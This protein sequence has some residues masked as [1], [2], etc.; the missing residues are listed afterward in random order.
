M[1]IRYLTNTGPK[2]IDNNALGEKR[3]ETMFRN[4]ETKGGGENALNFNDNIAG[5]T[6]EPVYKNRNYQ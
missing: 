3:V 6:Q 1:F 2:V 5:T 4:A